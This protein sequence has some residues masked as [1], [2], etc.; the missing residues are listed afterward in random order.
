MKILYRDD[1]YKKK[2]EMLFMGLMILILFMF[3]DK[4]NKVLDYIYF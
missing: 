1:F 3:K 4:E 2:Q